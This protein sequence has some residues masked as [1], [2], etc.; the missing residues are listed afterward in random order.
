MRA[1]ISYVGRRDY[2]NEADAGSY[3]IRIQRSQ[4]DGDQVVVRIDYSE[5]VRGFGIGP[6]AGAV[7]GV[8]LILPAN[9][10]DQ[11][12]RALSLAAASPSATADFAVLE[13][14]QAVDPASPA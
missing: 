3:E 1:R 2:G 6:R 12:A 11:L 5:P 7:N 13:P 10:A 9:V 8:M 14:K 4:H